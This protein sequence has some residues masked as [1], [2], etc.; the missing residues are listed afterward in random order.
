[1]HMTLCIRIVLAQYLRL[2]H[3]RRAKKA[4]I[5]LEPWVAHIPSCGRRQ[6]RPRDLENG[7]PEVDSTDAPNGPYCP[8]TQ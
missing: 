5:S 2:A 6:D 3:D 7:G 4:H 1:M 8:F